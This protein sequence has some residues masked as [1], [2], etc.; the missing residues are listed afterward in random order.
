MEIKVEQ[1]KPVFDPV[2]ISFTIT[3]ERLLKA[4]KYISDVTIKQ[5]CWTSS[6]L[7]EMFS[8]EQKLADQ[9]ID[10]LFL[11]INKGTK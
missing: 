8:D 7:Q 3:D 10:D 9:F 5:S 1:N 2:T 6:T 11:A 4:I